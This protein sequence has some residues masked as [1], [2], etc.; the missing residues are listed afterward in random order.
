MPVGTAGFSRGNFTAGFGR[1]RRAPSGTAP[2]VTAVTPA[3]LQRGELRWFTVTGTGFLATSAASM[4]AETTTLATAYVSPTELRVR[5]Q[6]SESAAAGNR[7]VTVTNPGAS[8]GTLA[9]AWA[10]SSFDL[11]A[12]PTL[13]FAN[14]A[15]AADLV[16][17]GGGSPAADGDAVEQVLDA[18]PGNNDGQVQAAAADRCVWRQNGVAAGRH[19]IEGSDGSEHY[20]QN[21]A[22]GESVTVACLVRRDSGS[23]E[24]VWGDFQRYGLYDQQSAGVRFRVG[25]D[26]GSLNVFASLAPVPAAGAWH[27]VLGSFNGPGTDVIVR[28]ESPAG[29]LSAAEPFGAGTVTAP[30]GNT[31]FPWLVG[32]FV[33]PFEFAGGRGEATERAILKQLAVHAGCQKVDNSVVWV[34]PAIGADITNGAYNPAAHDDTGAAGNAYRTFAAAHAAVDSSAGPAVILLREGQYT[35]A[36]GGAYQAFLIDKPN[37][38]ARAYNGEAVTWGP[39]AASPPVS[40]AGDG[41]VVYV[42]ATGVTLDGITVVGTLGRGQHL[43]GTTDEAVTVRIATAATDFTCRRCELYQGNHGAFKH[44]PTTFGA[45]VFEELIIGGAGFMQRD[46]GWYTNSAFTG[47]ITVRGCHI[48]GVTGYGMHHYDATGAFGNLKFYANLTARCGGYYHPTLPASGGILVSG[49]GCVLANNT[50]FESRVNGCLSIWN[51]VNDGFADNTI[52]NNVFAAGHALN[53]GDVADGGG[54]FDWGTGI[55]V[56]T[57]FKNSIQ[58][59]LQAAWDAAGGTTDASGTPGFRTQAPTSAAELAP[60]TA[61]NLA[62]AGT[63]QSSPYNVGLD[64]TQ[65]KP[66]LIAMPATP[67]KGCF[68]SA[69]TAAAGDTLSQWLEMDVNAKAM[70]NCYQNHLG[71]HGVPPAPVTAA[72]QSVGWA[73]DSGWATHRD[74]TQMTAANR[75]TWEA[76]GLV[77]GTSKYAYIRGLSLVTAWEIYAVVTR[78]AAELLTLF[79]SNDHQTG[80]PDVNDYSVIWDA[81]LGISAANNVTVSDGTNVATVAYTGSAGKV[82]WHFWRTGAGAAI[83]FE[84]T[85]MA[86]TTLTGG[87][88]VVRPVYRMILGSLA[89]GQWSDA[90]AGVERLIVW[91]RTLSAGERTAKQA[92]ISATHGVTL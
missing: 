2:T 20:Y 91:N 37:V 45:H 23:D 33:G 10:V 24:F 78:G 1:R 59:A 76:R 60:V 39:D 18:G 86:A 41:A 34:D 15:A 61:G 80:P 88:A 57:N 28:V 83:N 50:D 43:S 68:A 40:G 44:A 5:C 7:T 87:A 82:L 6:V 25:K 21:N 11:M 75:P 48:F 9:A 89:L 38:A 49:K 31:Y 81:W 36:A 14:W 30:L 35:P 74:P 8:P 63:A 46:H 19:A 67:H 42:G 84:A 52:A 17:A 27:A 12:E 55:V 79:G 73:T 51:T 70:G 56:A 72:G 90:N 85:G 53:F 16:K 32:R 64:P 47:G 3:S 65:T 62:G 13:R 66:R 92:E 4:G 69:A 77:G 54:N 26:G 58:S 29:V 71:P 22:P